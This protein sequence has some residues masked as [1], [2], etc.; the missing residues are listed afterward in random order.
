MNETLLAGSSASI[1][2]YRT[3]APLASS[4]PVQRVK[5]GACV[6]LPVAPSVAG[7][8]SLVEAEQAGY[9]RLA[10]AP[11]RSPAA[12]KALARSLVSTPSPFHF[13][14]CRA[15]QV[16]SWRKDLFFFFGLATGLILCK[17]LK[18][19]T[20]SQGLKLCNGDPPSALTPEWSCVQFSHI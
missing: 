18:K 19:E 13:S 11:A 7:A 6:P 12:Y 9:W 17:C 10:E 15:V 14:S 5:T 1:P 16:R 2:E 4:S 20:F 3:S 8:S